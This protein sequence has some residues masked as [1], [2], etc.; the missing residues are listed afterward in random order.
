ML[1]ALP[2]NAVPWF[3]GTIWLLWLTLIFGSGVYLYAAYT[4]KILETLPWW[5]KAMGNLPYQL[6]LTTAAKYGFQQ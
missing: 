5:A 3:F 2:R 4:L 1:P 6:I